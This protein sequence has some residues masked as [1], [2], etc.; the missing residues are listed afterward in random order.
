MPLLTG[1]G[2]FV[3]DIDRPGQL[4][5]RVVRSSVGHGRLLGVDAAAALARPGVVA[6][7]TGADIPDVR[8]PIRVAPTPAAERALQ[9]PLA[10]DRVRYVGEPVA[11][12][13]ATDPY[14]AEDAADDV[15]PE[16]EP[17]PVVADVDAAVDGA[18]ALHE[19]VPDNVVDAARIRNGGD[20][21]ELFAGAAVVD[22]A[23]LSVQRHTAIP[24]EARGLI[25]EPGGGHVLTVWGPAKV[26]HFNRAILATML[27][28]EPEAI[29]FLEPNVG[30][31]FGPRGE[32]Y[33]EDFLIPWL[34]LRLGRPVKWIED[35]RE[36]FV[37][38]NHS[39][40]QRCEIAMAADADGRLVAFRAVTR[41]ALGAYTRTH[42][43][44]LAKNTLSHLAGPYRWQGFEAEALGVL[45]NKTP[46]GTYRG[47]GQ[48]EPAFI[49]ERMVDRLA[50]R[51]GLDPAEMRRRNLVPVERMPYTVAL[52]ESEPEVIYDTGNFPYLFGRLLE[53]A[54]YDDLRAQA[55]ARRDRGEAVGVGVAAF[56][57]AGAIGGE[58]WARIEAGGDGRFVVHAGIASV[59]QGIA[60]TLSQIAADALGVPI[61]A[62]EVSHADTDAVPEGRGAFSSRSIVFGGSA[63]L[64]AAHD[65]LRNA[66]AAAAAELGVAPD[67]V[68]VADGVVRALSG[69]QRTVP[70]G[71]VQCEGRHHFRKSARSWSMGAAL[72][73]ASVDRDTAATTVER[74]VVACDVGRAI[75]PQI[76]HAQ[77]VGAAAQGIAGALLEELRHDDEGQPLTTSFMDYLMPTA[78]ELPEI[79]P[80]V[81]ELEQHRKESANPLGAKGAGEAGIV[82]IGAA[83]AGAVADAV[84]DPAAVS[85]L[86]A[87]P[88]RI[89]DAYGGWRDFVFDRQAART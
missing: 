36:H 60:T 72:A 45:L 85:A 89:G 49:R 58:E 82:G 14:L 23:V 61:D 65:L 8:I 44:V 22:R 26:K 39:R 64:G 81:L 48:Y 88:D 80:V 74:C 62:I 73:V 43:M 17:L 83:V 57:E 69:P 50:A 53:E 24:L 6:V 29:R 5:A 56:V 16:V 35:R 41:V 10:R 20:V 63:V 3:D 40:E 76:V 25:A 21:D 11:V 32:F 28:L 66:R 75:N 87:R 19:R 86:P 30:G 33:P 67:E 18:I 13:V 34:A 77:I 7:V 12:V 1:G 59:G 84:G 37:A 38:T 51:L 55:R 4:Y 70:L 52:G 15:A 2:A 78:A 42:G 46:A 31:G 68:E 54:G 27:G 79:V 71:T 9:P 47:P